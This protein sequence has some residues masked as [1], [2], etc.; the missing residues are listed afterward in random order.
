[1]RSS[2]ER[3]A[4]NVQSLLLRLQIN[5]TLRR[6]PQTGKGRDQFHIIVD[7]KA[8]IERFLYVIGAIGRSKQDHRLAI[9]DYL[10]ERAANT[11]QS[12]MTIAN[13]A[14]CT[15]RRSMRAASSFGP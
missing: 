2:S 13:A 4:R 9:L 11:N 7:G 6:T 1:M 3:L 5:G 15:Q 12:V 8:E 14:M 10:I